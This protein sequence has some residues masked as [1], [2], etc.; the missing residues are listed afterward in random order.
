MAVTPRDNTEN[1]LIEAH[2][3]EIKTARRDLDRAIQKAVDAG[4]PPVMVIA[5]ARVTENSVGAR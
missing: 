4:L 2:L 5:Y 3:L 1:S